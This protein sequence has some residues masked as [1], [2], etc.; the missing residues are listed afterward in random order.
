V[1]IVKF[2]ERNWGLAPISKRSRDNL[3]VPIQLP[4]NPYFPINTNFAA[5]IDENKSEFFNTI[6]TKETVASG[7]FAEG[8]KAFFSAVGDS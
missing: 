4:S 2:I 3:P 8:K 6:D 7:S 1:S 5:G